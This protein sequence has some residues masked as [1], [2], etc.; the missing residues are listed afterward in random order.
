MEEQMPL[1]Q[2]NLAPLPA[3]AAQTRLSR[4]PRRPFLAALQPIT[5]VRAAVLVLLRETARPLAIY[6][7]LDQLPPR[8]L[9]PPL[10]RPMQ[11][12]RVENVLAGLRKHGLVE[13]VP[14]THGKWR[15]C[16]PGDVPPET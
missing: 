11:W 15:A 14:G 2:K 9:K 7:M 1:P 3:R 16:P 13:R 10:R 8:L 12:A 6:E 4:A 5:D